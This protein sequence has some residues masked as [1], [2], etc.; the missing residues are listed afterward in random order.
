M[1]PLCCRNEC[2]KAHDP[3][4]FGSRVTLGGEHRTKNGGIGAVVYG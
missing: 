2:G 1:G 4:G 3:E